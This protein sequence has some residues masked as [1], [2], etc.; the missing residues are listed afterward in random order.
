MNSGH[1][2]I[3][4]F[5]SCPTDVGQEKDVIKK[6]CEAVNTSLT[7]SGCSISFMVQEWQQIIG[8]MGIMPQNT[9]DETINEYDIYV[10]ILWKRFGTSL[11]EVNPAT[12]RVYGSGTEKEFYDAY[13]R[14]KTNSDSVKMYFFC[15]EA[16][17][18]NPT[19]IELE[20][21]RKVQEFIELIR[22]TGWVNRFKDSSD[23]TKIITHL[24]F[25]IS[26]RLCLDMHNSI[27]KE[28]LIAETTTSSPAIQTMLNGLIAGVKLTPTY[29]ERTLT[30]SLERED[31]FKFE[32]KRIKLNQI[33]SFERTLVVLGD[34]GSGKSTELQHLAHF[35]NNADTPLVPVYRSLREYNNEDIESFLPD[36]WRTINEEVLLIILDGLDEVQPE[37]FASAANKISS[38]SEKF[39]FAKIVVSC[40]I[41][42][43]EIPGESTS[44]TLPGFRCYFLNDLTQ[45]DVEYF[46]ERESL[47]SSVFLNEVIGNEE[48]AELTNKPLFL[49]SLVSLYRDGGLINLNRT[50]IY[51]HFVRLSFILDESSFKQNTESREAKIKVLE[52]IALS[53][54]AT[55]K[56]I[57][58]EPELLR[59]IG[60]R[61]KLNLIKQTSAFRKE[62][63]LWRFEHKSIQEYFSARVLA[64]LSVD[65]IKSLIA[66]PPNQ[67][68][69]KPNW[70]NTL[71]LLISIG[72]KHNIVD[73]IVDW[74]IDNDPEVIV[75]F[76]IDRIPL[77]TRIWIVTSIF[78]D[79]KQKKIR[80]VSNKFSD[81]DLARFAFSEEMQK[82]L[83]NELRDPNN[84][85]IT[86]YN[87]LNI[88]SEYKDSLYP[89]LAADLKDVLISQITS[90]STDHYYT[91]TVLEIISSFRFNDVPTV[92][93]I[94]DII[95]K[96]KNQYVRSGLYS[97]ILSA[98][99]VNE[100]IDF[101]I[102]GA[103]IQFDPGDAT[104][105]SD[106]SF[107]DESLG[108]VKGLSRASSL[109][110]IKKVTE[111][112]S[113]RHF[114]LEFMDSETG[115]II[116]GIV[117][118]AVHLFKK[119]VAVFDVILWFFKFFGLPSQK[120]YADL[121]ARFFT[122][123]QTNE[124]AFFLLL[125]DRVLP[126]FEKDGLLALL[127]NKQII[128]K[129]IEEYLHRNFTNDELQNIYSKIILWR[130]ES[131]KP[132][133]RA[134][135][136]NAITNATSLKLV[137]PKVIDYHE[138][139]V[140][141]NQESFD[142]LFDSV[143]FV[144]V[145]RAIFASLGRAEV[146]FSELYELN[147]NKQFI[148]DVFPQSVV[149]LLR[150]LTRSGAKVTF[151][152]TVD[153][154]KTDGFMNFLI[155]EIYGHLKN[156]S[157]IKVTE[158][159]KE[160][161]EGWVN[162]KF[163][164][165]DIE[166]AIT[167]T[168]SDFGGLTF[169]YSVKLMWYFI[170]KFGIE[171]Y[172]AKML[173]FTLMDDFEP[174]NQFEQK[175]PF[176]YLEQLFDKEVVVS[177]VIKNLDQSDKLAN[178]IWENNAAYA[179]SN[180]LE[181]SYRFIISE[182]KNQNR[183]D[184][185][186]AA[187]L[188]AF[189]QK[190][191]DNAVL[192]DILHALNSDGLIWTIIEILIKN[193]VNEAP[194]IHY[195]EAKIGTSSSFENGLF[196]AKYLLMLNREKGFYFYAKYILEKAT[197]DDF[198]FPTRIYSLG[199]FNN[200]ELLPTA[201]ELLRLS[202]TKRFRSHRFNDL[203]RMVLDMVSNLAMWSK[204]N[205]ETVKAELFDFKDEYEE[206]LQNLDFIY[207][208]V[209]NLEEN[210]YV[211]QSKEL[212]IDDAVKELE[213]LSL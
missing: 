60:K 144:E 10:G 148:E 103:G 174:Q 64:L 52:R 88:L 193:K 197:P 8:P 59:I 65:K 96:S 104:E 131:V 92:A 143:Q 127:I 175:E 28:I 68:R 201:L 176:K 189:Y 70:V 180:S 132:E 14:Y 163:K 108:I 198:S 209:K 66:F 205:L 164:V 36:D 139:T 44:G 142:A 124:S 61:Q 77:K 15:K 27:K 182:L 91:Y 150:R 145:L 120:N 30:D 32:S 42:F 110:S 191:Q 159:Q 76:E 4:I 50:Q 17:F 48:L 49:S 169:D 166:N 134:Y 83:I 130:T 86:K 161:V 141:R 41:N 72:D 22:H 211:N 18:Q 105:R 16:T 43:Y 210:F 94:I 47:E 51:E 114:R 55:G 160:F 45:S 192:F 126:E 157:T 206:S 128:D 203:E 35:Y 135:Y 212:T 154:L 158:L 208:Y 113:N 81:K 80:I 53:M 98:E 107:Y 181:Q 121:I 95:G 89:T 9:I 90:H 153:F 196:I 74:L 195:L 7:F 140:K 12:G 19:L 99:L 170:Q 136:E 156:Y 58:T 199:K 207:L 171:L 155:D 122:E 213:S 24:L 3:K 102:E 118:N 109:D 202:L 168:T 34:A 87:A 67:E 37:Y 117:D 152:Q 188:R 63:K 20:Q 71:S 26:I 56:N 190:T 194:L 106:V 119:D 172:E 116:N 184:H 187:V 123:T 133:L 39:R 23:F 149:N 167:V 46:I 79:Y 78:N 115:G 137:K 165:A 1:K 111:L 75:K 5:V 146:G 69:V 85:S 73:P 6:A 204:E 82:F 54:E 84:G 173:D 183:T 177:A 129:I 33:V 179:I 138:L 25:E 186:R 31:L 100:Y 97:L 200:L 21:Y 13:E 2:L 112:F 29:I 151:Q 147:K 57:L 11:N 185:S 162:E 93:K 40:R 101:F 38:F 62:G 178:V 125:K